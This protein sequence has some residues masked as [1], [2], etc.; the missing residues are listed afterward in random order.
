MSVLNLNR[1]AANSITSKSSK[2]NQDK[3][4]VVNSKNSA[5]ITR[6]MLQ[7]GLE[8]AFDHQSPTIQVIPNNQQTSIHKHAYPNTIVGPASSTENEN[9]ICGVKKRGWLYVGRIAHKKRGDPPNYEDILNYL[10]HDAEDAVCFRISGNNIYSNFKL[11][12]PFAI[13]EKLLQPSYWPNDVVVRDFVFRSPSSS[14]NK[15][16]ENPVHQNFLEGALQDL[17]PI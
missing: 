17:H 14:N 2:A 15:K 12:V 5:G 16:N 3:G 10:K 11:G 4:E 1:D 7:A 8:E 13:K 6:A 9:S